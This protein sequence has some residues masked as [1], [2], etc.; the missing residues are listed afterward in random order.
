VATRRRETGAAQ[1]ISAGLG[2]DEQQ[3]AAPRPSQDAEVA[4]TAACEQEQLR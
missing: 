2:H 4:Q 1:P 3:R